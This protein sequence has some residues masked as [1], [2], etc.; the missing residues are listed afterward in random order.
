MPILFSRSCQYAMQAVLYMATQPSDKF[1]YIKDLSA[2]LGIPLHFLAKI[3]QNLAKKGILNSHKGRNGG[4]S[5][6][7]NPKKI[8]LL[9]IIEAVDGLDSLKTCVLGLSSCSEKDPCPIHDTWA[10]IREKLREMLSTQS[11]ED[12]SKNLID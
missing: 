5:L 12:L 11:I 10:V 9:E 8:R 2:H 4:F 3:F 1:H 6:G 7:K